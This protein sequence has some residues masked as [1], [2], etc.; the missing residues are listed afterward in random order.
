MEAGDW[1]TWVGS[2][3]AVVAAVASVAVWWRGKGAVQ[4]RFEPVDHGRSAVLNN[5][6]ATAK[7]VRVRVGSASDVAD[8]ESEASADNVAPGEAIRVLVA[9]TY[10]SSA[11]FAV[12]VTW[13]GRFGKRKRWTHLP[14]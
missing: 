3:G 2:T 9:A 4:W 5:G 8:I 6:S 14:H 1:A 11:D 13:R 10:G 12:V 7:Q